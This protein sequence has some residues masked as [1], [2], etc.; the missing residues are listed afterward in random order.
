MRTV[1]ARGTKKT[2]QMQADRETEV[3]DKASR[4]E[5]EKQI[6]QMQAD[7]DELQ[8]KYEK[9]QEEMNQLRARSNA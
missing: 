2:K 4:Q 8:K 5:L 7:M 3:R 1:H 9:Q 6:E